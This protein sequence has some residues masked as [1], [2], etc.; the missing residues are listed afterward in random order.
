MWAHIPSVNK[1]LPYFLIVKRENRLFS[2]LEKSC[3]FKEESLM[4]PYDL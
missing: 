3:S 4:I 2:K 1:I